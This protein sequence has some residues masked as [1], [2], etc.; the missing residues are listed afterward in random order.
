MPVTGQGP[1]GSTCV[2]D[3]DLHR[4]ARTVHALPD[5]LQHPGLT[6]KQMC[7]PG[8]VQHKPVFPFHSN[9]WAIARRPTAQHMQQ[10]HVFKWGCGVT[11]QV[12]A[13][14]PCI[15]KRHAPLEAMPFGFC[16]QAIET[17]GIGLFQCQ[18]K[19]AVDRA[20]PENPITGQ[21]GKPQRD[22]PPGAF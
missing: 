22:D 6:A 17:F 9:P 2:A 8:D 12:G 18:R 1:S 14:R 20:P 13:K 3:S 11:V 7:G 21:A 4:E 5:I 10:A 19:G 15:G 16:I